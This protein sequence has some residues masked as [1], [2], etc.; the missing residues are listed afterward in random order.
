VLDWA[1]RDG[2]AHEPALGGGALVSIFFTQ[3][4]AFVYTQFEAGAR[5]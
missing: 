1:A 2:G 3:V 4:F 5:C